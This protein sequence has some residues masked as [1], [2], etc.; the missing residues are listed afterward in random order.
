MRQPVFEGRA[1]EPVVVRDEVHRFSAS[2]DPHFK[3]DPKGVK[4]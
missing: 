2:A 4:S 1:A 3:P